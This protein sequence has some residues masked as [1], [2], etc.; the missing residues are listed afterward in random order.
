MINYLKKLFSAP[1][2][3]DTDGKSREDERNFDLL[4]YDGIRAMRMGKADY[5]EQ[6]F[7]RA[8]DIR[9]DAETLR[10]LA[11]L[12]AATGR[13]GDAVATL[14]RLVE[15]EPQAADAMVM[16]AG[17]LYASGDFEESR[18]QAQAALAVDGDNA[19]ALLA[20]GKA[21]WR[22]GDEL[23]AIADLT[24]AIGAR[25]GYIE[26]VL[27]RAEVLAAMRQPVEALADVE[28]ALGIDGES[29]QALMLKGRLLVLTG[30]AAGAVAAWDALVA[31]N[32]FNFDAYVA[33][34]ETLTDQGKPAEA[35]VV[36]DEALEL[37]SSVPQLYKARGRARLAL[38]DKDGAADDVRKTLELHPEDAAGISGEFSNKP[39]EF[40]NIVGIFK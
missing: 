15:V 31:V 39:M 4:K 12:Y 9:D 7:V 3:G 40:D 23:A 16:M 10:H 13:G 24:R 37:S 18:R 27:T 34:A 38:G 8:L 20:L 11:S 2:G 33:K 28:T 6:C 30:D 36:I 19:E 5:A 35:V 21:D 32:P 14:A 17:L 29:E 22:L 1:S 25:E 26:A